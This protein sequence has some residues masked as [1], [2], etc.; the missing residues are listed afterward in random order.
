MQ[1]QNDKE[2]KT[3]NVEL[4][5]YDMFTEKEE[6]KWEYPVYFPPSTP[7]EDPKQLFAAHV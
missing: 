7:D 2:K 5:K 4:L 1:I 6:R 3:V